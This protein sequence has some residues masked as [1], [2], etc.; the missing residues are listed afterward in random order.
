MKLYIH[1]DTTD[2]SNLEDGCV[3]FN[4]CDPLENLD[5]ITQHSCKEIT[6][7]NDAL[8]CLKNQ[9]AE[10]LLSIV[11]T[12]CRKGGKIN[13]SVVD[14]HVACNLISQ[15]LA[16]IEELNTLIK[17]VSSVQDVYR[18]YS[19]LQKNSITVISSKQD[20]FKTLIK[21]VRN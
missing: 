5:S 18:I 7:I 19:I 1:D 14:G 13:L 2:V 12:K 17:E 16:P 8:S 6:F 9:A 10:E 15:N 4:V 20:G 21:A 11:A 3:A